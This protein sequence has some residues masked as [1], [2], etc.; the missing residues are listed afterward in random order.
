[1]G[2]TTTLR[3][4]GRFCYRATLDQGLIEHELDHVLVGWSDVEAPSY[5]PEEVQATRWQSV[6]ALQAALQRPDHGY[7]AW[8]E[9]ALALAMDGLQRQD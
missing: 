3:A 4:V 6:F 2:L 9:Q 7:T 5:H 1:M 8:L